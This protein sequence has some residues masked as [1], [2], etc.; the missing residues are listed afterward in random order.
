MGQ[1]I[2]FKTLSLPTSSQTL[3]YNIWE[4]FNINLF[5]KCFWLFFFIFKDI[6]RIET[7]TSIP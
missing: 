4:N 7:D 3:N 5:W 1:N 6:I 2:L